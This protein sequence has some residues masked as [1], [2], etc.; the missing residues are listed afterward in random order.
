M[1]AQYLVWQ[2]ICW[3]RRAELKEEP[4]FKNPGYVPGL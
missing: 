1:H 3:Y 4:P 2:S